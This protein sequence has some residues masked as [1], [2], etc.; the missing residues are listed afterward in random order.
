MLYV[1]VNDRSDETRHSK[2][3]CSS[4]AKWIT[5]VLLLAAG[6][7]WSF[8]DQIVSEPAAQES[9]EEIQDLFFENKE[10]EDEDD[11]IDVEEI[12]KHLKDEEGMLKLDLDFGKA[13]PPFFIRHDS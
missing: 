13:S 2:K 7:A 4:T 1:P 6:F 12:D 8:K 3:K 5:V 11:I 9:F 10:V